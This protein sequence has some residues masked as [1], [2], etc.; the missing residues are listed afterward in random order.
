ML[1]PYK[2]QIAVCPPKLDLRQ[3]RNRA[4]EL[5][6]APKARKAEALRRI[7][8]F[9][10]RYSNTDK[11]QLDQADLSLFDTQLVIARELDFKSWPKLKHHLESLSGSPGR[12]RKPPSCSGESDAVRALEKLRSRYELGRTG[13]VVS[14][15]LSGQNVSDSSLVHLRAFSTLRKLCLINTRV[16]NR[17]LEFLDGKKALPGCRVYG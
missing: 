12:G 2:I 14:V 6:K 13:H 4:K 10:P 3:L 8:Q 7:T 1:P 15:N 9:H 16:T 11:A 17:G 5:H